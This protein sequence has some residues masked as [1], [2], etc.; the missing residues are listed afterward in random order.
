V[1]CKYSRFLDELE[2]PFTMADPFLQNSWVD[3]GHFVAGLGK[4]KYIIGVPGE[5]SPANEAVASAL[6]LVFHGQK[7]IPQHG[8]EGY[9]VIKSGT[10]A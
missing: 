4:D 6:G 5:F 3:Y 9:W 1:R 8:D 2:L 10:F 7:E